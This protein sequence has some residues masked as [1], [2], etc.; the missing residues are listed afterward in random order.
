MWG[1]FNFIIYI[2]ITLNKFICLLKCNN[3]KKLLKSYLLKFEILIKFKTI[4]VFFIGIFW[5]KVLIFKEFVYYIIY[6]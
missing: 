4:E 3:L 5:Q 2:T 6:F 1:D